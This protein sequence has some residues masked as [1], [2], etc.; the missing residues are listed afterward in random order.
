LK[1][2]K[3]FLLQPGVGESAAKFLEKSK[4]L[5]GTQFGR[6]EI[7]AKI[8]AGGMGEV[9]AG[10]DAEL[11]REVAVKILPPEFSA[12]EN[13][14]QRFRQEARAAS[15]LNHPNII[16]IYEIGENEH[17]AFLVTELIDGRTLREVIKRD[18]LSLARILKIIEQAAGALVAAHRARIVHRDIKPENIMVRHDG[19]VKVLDFGLA[20]PVEMRNAEFGMRND[21]AVES[22][23]DSSDEKNPPAA[24]GSL[25]LTNPGMIMG[26]VRY[27]SPEQAR[28][29][30]VDERTDIWSLGV[31]LYEMLTGQAPFDGRTA[32]DTIA[33][34]IYKEPPQILNF[35]PNAPAELQRIL[36]KSLQKDREERYQHVKDFALDVKELLYEIE[37]DLSAER[38]RSVPPDRRQPDITENPTMIH[39]TT[40][41]NHP[42]KDAAFPAATGPNVQYSGATPKKRSWKIPA[43]AALGGVALLA[44]LSF[45]FYQFFFGAN[46]NLA[47]TAF[48]RPQATRV[49]TD[50]KVSMPAISPDGKYVAYI[51]GDIG[52][53]S[54]VVRQI[55][56]DSVVTVVPPTAQGLFGVTFSPDG[57]YVYYLLTSADNVLNTLYRVPTLGG[58]SKK[59]IEDVDSAVTFSPDGKRLAFQ[60]NVSKEV[61]TIIFTANIDGGDIQQLIRSDETEFNVIGTPKWSPDGQKM[62]ARAFNSFGGIVENNR[63]AEISLAEKKLNVLPTRELFSV[64]DFVWFKDGSG[65]LF[66]GQETQNSPI[67]I[68]RAAYPSGEYAPVTSDINNYN[69]LGLSEDGKTIVTVKSNS[70]SSIWNFNPATKQANQITA[71]SANLDGAS[72]LAQSRDGGGRLVHTRKNGNELTLWLMDAD[73]GN[74]RLLTNEI[75]SIFYRPQITPDG[76]RIVF[77]SKQSG[78]ARI[79]RVDADG[80]NLVQ[81]T[82]EKAN[83]GDFNPQITP[84][85][86]WVIYQEQASGANAESAFLKVPIDGGSAEPTLLYQD[87]EFNVHNHAISPDGKFLAFDSYRKSDF[88][89]KVRI[90]AL[91]NG[92]FGGIV[93][94]FDA[95]AILS[96]V[97]TPDGKSL[98]FLSNRSGVPNLWR[99]PLDGS[100]PQPITEFKSG[101]IFNYNW[102]ADGKT[103]FI[104]RGN[105]NSDLI[106]I[107]D[108]SA[109]KI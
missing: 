46:R 64:F 77:S 43:A 16:T 11:G 80:K 38:L 92:A 68:Y 6:Y 91:E 17:G 20:K 25:Q 83:H 13:R 8:G 106:L 98:T 34:V 39:Q 58:E 57:D 75:K 15:A 82:R 66:I 14:K 54:L 105:V 76:R 53:R 5:I 87:K 24:A 22:A 81:L 2:Q 104:V 61:I 94:E 9:Y 1:K 71:E 95:D 74:A 12:D 28:G 18:S 45:G 102:S 86:K 97:W 60:R 35:V 7:R 4:M 55:S 19:I 59:L 47:A 44:V 90:A 63:I 62:L 107:R 42:T 70:S 23:N 93:K 40:G 78:S 48:E 26:S 96:Y 21:E 85:G 56:T 36:R 30:A 100:A 49:N 65:F 73:A 10:F 3:R 27:M 41:A 52:S 109:A 31:V 37:H 32:S 88:D 108:S 99:L 51:S 33:A 84:D 79:W 29:L 101:R 103:L 89:K 50:G 69:A 72:G 67:Q